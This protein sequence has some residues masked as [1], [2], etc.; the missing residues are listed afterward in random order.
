MYIFP[1]HNN[2]HNTHHQPHFPLLYCYLMND[3]FENSESNSKSS[4]NMCMYLYEMHERA[5]L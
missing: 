5:G 3:E 2:H 1:I 4:V